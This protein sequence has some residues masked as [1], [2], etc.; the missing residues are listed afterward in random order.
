M[1]L[2]AK[3]AKIALVKLCF[4]MQG[5]TRG[6]DPFWGKLEENLFDSI[7]DC[8]IT[9]SA[10][11]TESVDAVERSA[12]DGKVTTWLNRYIRN[13]S[14]HRLFQ[15]IRF[16]TGSSNFSPNTHIKL[17][18]VDQ[19]PPHLSPFSKTCFEI[20]ILPRQYTSFT[21]L[22]DNIGTYLSNKENWVIHDM[23]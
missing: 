19:T 3:A 18:F 1:S 2:L 23:F 14:K 4:A 16:V 13:Y 12:K 10:K 22:K 7:Y 5:L 6:M 17:Q 8:P 11:V 15:F 21:H 20:L 9:S